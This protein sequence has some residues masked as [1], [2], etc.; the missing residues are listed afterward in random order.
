M[1]IFFVDN[2]GENDSLSIGGEVFFNN[3]ADCNSPIENRRA[4][5]DGRFG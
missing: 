5:G 1:S 4:S 2:Y 3:T